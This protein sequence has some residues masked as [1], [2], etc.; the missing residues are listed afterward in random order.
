MIGGKKYFPACPLGVYGIYAGQRVK[1]QVP[2]LQSQFMLNPK[3]LRIM[4][5]D[6]E[7]KA[8]KAGKGS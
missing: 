8:L 1:M 6:A 4:E 2:N 7:V 5:L 3:D